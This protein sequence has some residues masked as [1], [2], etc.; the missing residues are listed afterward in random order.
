MS[1]PEKR[2]PLISMMLGP[3]TL[4]DKVELSALSSMMMRCRRALVGIGSRTDATFSRTDATLSMGSIFLTAGEAEGRRR[5]VFLAIASFLLRRTDE[6]GLLRGY[7]RM[8]AAAPAHG[9]HALGSG[10]CLIR[11]YGSTR[12]FRT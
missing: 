2:Q 6:H 8:R 1:F 12:V 10:H 4:R 5:V 3:V 11:L 7:R 9:G